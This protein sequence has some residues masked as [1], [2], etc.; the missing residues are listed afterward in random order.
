MSSPPI[1]CV[2]RWCRIEAAAAAPSNCARHT[3]CAPPATAAIA[4]ALPKVPQN[5]T[6]PSSA[7]SS[8]SSPMRR[9][10]SAACP[11]IVC[12]SCRTS[13]GPLVVPEVV[14]VR[15]GAPAVASSGPASPARPSSGN[16]GS[17]A[18]VAVLRDLCG[19][20]TQRRPARSSIGREEK[21]AGKSTCANP[22]WVT[23]ATARV[24]RS[25]LP[26][27]AARK[28]VLIWIASA[29]SRAQAKIAAR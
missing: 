5:G 7:A 13:L 29:P 6:A 19:A 16:T 8:A 15:H 22:H 2:I 28:R 25:K 14:K 4:A 18:S 10:T 3:I 26:T 1:R 20:S 12:W 9:A 23:S 11:A 27:S 24:R 17:P 21:I